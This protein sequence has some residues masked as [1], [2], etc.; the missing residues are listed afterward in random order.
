MKFAAGLTVSG[1]VGFLLLEAL[2]VVMVPVSGWVLGMLVVLVKIVLV[3]SV[4]LLAAGVIGIGVWI[5]RRGQKASV[6][7]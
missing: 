4:V 3:V 1:I 6:E 7:V 2:K 5:Y